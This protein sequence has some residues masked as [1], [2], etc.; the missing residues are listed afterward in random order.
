MAWH[1]MGTALPVILRY[2]YEVTYKTER[3]CS[4]FNF[5]FGALSLSDE[6]VGTNALSQYEGVALHSS[7]VPAGQG[8]RT[9]LAGYTTDHRPGDIYPGNVQTIDGAALKR[10]ANVPN[11]GWVERQGS[12]PGRFIQLD[13][14]GRLFKQ[15]D[16]IETMSCELEA[17][18]QVPGSSTW[19]PFPFSPMTISNG[20][21]RPARETFSA[22]LDQAAIKFRVRRT[23][24]EPTEATEVSELDLTRIKIFRDTDALYPA[25][26][27]RGMLIKAT[28]QLNGR[29]DRYSALAKAKHW[30]WDSPQPWDGSYP[31]QGGHWVWR[32][33]VN[34]AWLFIYFARGGFLNPTAAP[35]H[36]GLAGWLD[37]PAAGNGERLFGA[38]VTNARIDYGTLVAWGQFCDAAGLT[39]RMVLTDQRSAGSVLDDIAAA[40]RASKTWAPGKLSVWWEAPDQPVVA[41]FG[42]SNIVA[43]TFKVAYLTDDTVDEF[44]VSYTRADDDYNADTVYAKVPGVVLPVNQSV[45]QAVYSMPRAQAQRL[46][47]LLA[48]SKHYHRRTITWESTLFG[49]TVATGDVIHLAHDLTAWAASGRLVAL[50]AAAGHVVEVE[51]SREVELPE[52]GGD[53]WLWICPPGGDRFSVR[54]APPAGRARTLAVVG[55]WPLVSAPGWLDV[56]TPNTAADPFFADTVPE[57]WTFLGGPTATPGKRARIIKM[58][59]SSARRVRI[60]ARDEVPEYYPLEWSLGSVPEV[61]SGDRQV[62]RAYNPALEP[63]DGGWRLSWELEGATAAQVVVAIDG[64]AGQQVPIRGHLTV[65]GREISLPAYPAGTRL[66]ITIMPVALAAPLAVEHAE[67]QVTV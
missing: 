14:S 53:Y 54:C 16:G 45:R 57:D 64:G 43:G 63:A 59:P 35:A 12:Q 23:T 50:R 24:P 67:L 42:A 60:T 25:Q 26:L 34:P 56:A 36:L 47:N 37:E 3:L 22:L 65:P 39:C 58:E 52:G 15:G 11:D 44:G 20:S 9:Q 48:A 13:V 29:V 38:G 7:T 46:V 21:T 30:A 51:L 5:G 61:P 55:A 33:T 6:R 49:L 10:S 18:Y 40:G 31:G 32:E 27:R 1:P 8:D 19:V 4:I 28:G 66:T 41:A 62:A 2:G 17:H